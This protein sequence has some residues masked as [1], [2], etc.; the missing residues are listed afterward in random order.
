MNPHIKVPQSVFLEVYATGLSDH[1][2]G[3]KLGVHCTTIA[4]YRDKL[5]LDDMWEIKDVSYA[6]MA[7]RENLTG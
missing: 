7:K 5:N 6:S 1:A 3:R 2:I 4:G